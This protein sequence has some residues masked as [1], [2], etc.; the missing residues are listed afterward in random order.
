VDIHLELAEFLMN[1]LADTYQDFEDDHSFIFSVVANIATYSS[2]I[3]ESIMKLYMAPIH[4]II[5]MPLTQSCLAFFHGAN[6]LH[7]GCDCS[8]GVDDCLV[9]DIEN[10]G[11]YENGILGRLEDSP[12]F[13][14]ATNNIA[15]LR[16]LLAL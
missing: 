16:K 14:A 9:S 2:S 7:I 6:L 12:L 11:W 4:Q 8:D 13:T 5:D 10:N 15:A 1:D 3:T